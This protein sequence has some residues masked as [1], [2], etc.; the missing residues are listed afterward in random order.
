MSSSSS[1]ASASASAPPP[2][3][4]PSQPSNWLSEWRSRTPL[5]VR[6]SIMV[7]L[8]I[9]VI[10][11]L[12]SLS[13]F[14]GLVPFRA[15]ARFEIWRLITSL[16][17]Q[18]GIFT[19][20]FVLLML[21]TQ[22]PAQEIRAGSVSFLAK[23]LFTGLLI[24]VAFTAI[25][26]MLYL[27]GGNDPSSFFKFFAITPS[28]GLWPVLMSSITTNA[29]SDPTG[30]SSFLCLTIPNRLYPWFLVFIFSFISMFP[31]LD[32]FTGVVVG[33]L[34]HYKV[35]DFLNLTPRTISNIE[36]G[37]GLA[38]RLGMTTKEGF[39]YGPAT[40]LPPGARQLDRETAEAQWAA[41]DP[42][43]RQRLQQQQ[44]RQQQ[45]Q[46]GG[47]YGD[48]ESGSSASR[49]HT[50]PARGRS[51]PG[52]TSSTTQ[53]NTSTGAFI[54]EGHSLGGNGSNT[55][56]RDNGE[57]DGGF[58]TSSGPPS[59]VSSII[60]SLFG[61][62]G[63]GGGGGGGSSQLGYSVVDTTGVL[64]SP[65]HNSLS[66]GG[67]GG[68]GGGGGSSQG[69]SIEDR[70]RAAVAAAEARI[71][72]QDNRGINAE[73]SPRSQ[74][75]IKREIDRIPLM[76][77]RNGTSKPSVIKKGNTDVN[78]VMDDEFNG[79]DVDLLYAPVVN[80]HVTTTRAGT[81]T[82]TTTAPSN[83]IPSRT[84]MTAPSTASTSSTAAS[85]VNGVVNGN[86]SSSITSSKPS[87]VS[88]SDV[89]SLVEMGFNKDE[90]INA[91][92]KS[93]GDMGR[94]LELLTEES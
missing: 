33:H 91:L 64:G 59:S 23:L 11:L 43:A 12:F 85:V 89:Q 36:T 54:G 1:S 88:Q 41:F 56:G 70:R 68:G 69:V 74:Q 44:Q 52:S 8:P 82:T 25:S 73:S 42:I 93:R 7:V 86:T 5:V 10:S 22:M 58:T 65:D 39:I 57:Q 19:L 20:L 31:L 9:T 32:L 94:A 37:T 28:Q 49:F 53:P 29:L 72:A 63:G 77:G 40:V 60:G 75:Q 55:G 71:R 92:T 24:N 66:N 15:T 18:G 16:L 87:F 47:G 35:L 45:Q 30:S 38:V 34:Q 27:I 46:Q 90:A 83:T 51:T 2:S 3:P 76:E 4:S 84:V 81:A 6:F 14:T 62:G 67:S 17:D 50:I 26:M 21:G 13:S 61:R 79:E 78:T 48:E 80:N